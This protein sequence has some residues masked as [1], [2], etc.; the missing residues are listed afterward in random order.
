MAIHG[1]ATE[2][3]FMAAQYLNLGRRPIRLTI[4]LLA[5][6]CVFLFLLKETKI[7]YVMVFVVAV[8][9]AFLSIPLKYKK[10]FR[11]YKALSEPF[12]VEVQDKG[13][14]FVRTN[15]QG[16]VPWSEILDW[17]YNKKCLLLYPGGNV[18]HLIPSHFFQSEV[19]Y[20]E[21]IALLKSKLSV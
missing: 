2:Q 16:L 11:E 10:Y 18:F 21:F 15:A 9:A 6:F 14:Y 19:Q 7:M 8:V 5:I 12:T 1:A 20:N 13:L 4:F 3:D 17:R